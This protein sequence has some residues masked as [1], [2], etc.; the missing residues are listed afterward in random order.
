MFGADGTSHHLGVEMVRQHIQQ[1]RLDRERLVEEF[2]VEV[3]LDVMDEDTGDAVVIV[4]RS[5]GTTHHLKDIS[6][7]HVDVAPCFT[8][9]KFRTFIQNT[10]SKFFKLIIGSSNDVIIIRLEHVDNDKDELI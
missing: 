9:V 2:F 1:T 8:V 7:R 6:D 4:L 3:F 5:T 10:I